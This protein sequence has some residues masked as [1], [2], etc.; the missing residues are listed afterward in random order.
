MIFN[1]SAD[2]KHMGN[3]FS[4]QGVNQLFQDKKDLW[5]PSNAF[6]AR[7][8]ENKP[9]VLRLPLPNTAGEERLLEQWINKLKN[10]YPL[11]FPFGHSTPLQQV[12]SSH[13]HFH[14]ISKEHKCVSIAL[15]FPWN[16]PAAVGK[17]F[18][19]P[20]S[21]RQSMA[22]FN[23]PAL[24]FYMQ[25]F[26]ELCRKTFSDNQYN[27]AEAYN[28]TA[29]VETYTREVY[30]L[31]AE[32][33]MKSIDAFW[34]TALEIP[35]TVNSLL[36]GTAW[37][38][39][40]ESLVG[41]LLSL[42]GVI[43]AI[44]RLNKKDKALDSLAQTGYL[45]A[46]LVLDELNNSGTRSKE[47]IPMEWD[48]KAL[49]WQAVSKQLK[50]VPITQG[51]A[52]SGLADAL[53]AFFTA[54][55]TASDILGDDA[56]YHMLLQWNELIKQWDHMLKNKG[57]EEVGKWF[58]KMTRHPTGDLAKGILGVVEIQEVFYKAL[59]EISHYYLGMQSQQGNKKV[60]LHET[61]RRLFPPFTID[62]KDSIFPL[63][64]PPHLTS[65][66]C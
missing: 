17:P 32:G 37:N 34:D 30:S 62:E 44:H 19:D 2:V 50:F 7:S 25:Q 22:K 16:D 57:S 10:R 39:L 43:D 53:F 54:A 33:A 46:K 23:F 48:E 1:Q 60:E 45:L 6:F 59:N 61:V 51:F 24:M 12:F 3:T 58:L 14:K 66:I 27:Q 31:L 56:H 20:I 18:I 13:R 4:I 28:L 49:L 8:K 11:F 64:I 41:Q 52:H 40:R 63:K 26:C 9:L 15:L 5:V 21:R 38:E 65:L 47:D 35:E 36:K 55:G 42:G 29:A